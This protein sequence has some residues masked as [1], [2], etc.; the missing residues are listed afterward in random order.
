MSFNFRHDR[1]D[2]AC[3]INWAITVPVRVTVESVPTAQAPRCLTTQELAAL[4]HELGREGSLNRE[5]IRVLTQLPEL[6]QTIA[7]E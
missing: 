3:P 4:I 2:R 7:A 1:E 5:Q 6:A